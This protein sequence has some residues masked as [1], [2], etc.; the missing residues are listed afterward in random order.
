[1]KAAILTGIGKRFITRINDR[2]VELHPFEQIVVDVIRA[3][4]DLEMTISPRTA[5][6]AA[7]FRAG[8]GADAT[9]AN[10][11]L[12][13]GQKGEQRKHVAFGQRRG[14]ANEVILMAAEGRAGIVIDVIAN[15]ANLIGDAQILDR[16]HQDGVAGAVVAQ[17]VDEAEAFG[18]AVFEVA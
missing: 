9:G 18:R 15:E 5:Q 14:T 3:L 7:K 11:K 10:V 16:L 13:E 17:N 1:M 6:V 12:P 8:R 4:A 2:A